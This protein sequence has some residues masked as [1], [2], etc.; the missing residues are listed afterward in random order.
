M[1]RV[2]LAA[3][4]LVILA[5]LGWIFFSSP[6]VFPAASAAYFSQ[7]LGEAAVENVV[8]VGGRSFHVRAGVVEPLSDTGRTDEGSVL[9]VSYAHAVVARNPLLDLEGTDI[10][11]LHEGADSLAR[12]AQQF[13]QRQSSP[14]DAQSVREHLFPVEFLHDLADL[15]RSRRAFL[16]SGSADDFERYIDLLKEAAQQGHRSASAFTE[17]YEKVVDETSLVSLLKGF[18]TKESALASLERIAAGYKRVEEKAGELE[19]CYR[20]EIGACDTNDL[21]LEPLSL[22]PPSP[23]SRTIGRIISLREDAG[24]FPPTTGTTASLAKSTCIPESPH[25]V[26]YIEPKSQRS[27]APAFDLLSDIAFFRIPE[28]L[29]ERAQ[30][31]QAFDA[32][33]VTFLVYTPTAFY[34]CPESADDL[35]RAAATLAA[36]RVAR[37]ENPRD[38]LARAVTPS[39]GDALEYLNRALFDRPSAAVMGVYRMFKDKGASFERLV[40]EIAAFGDAD[41]NLEQ[42]G[43]PVDMSLSFLFSTRSG[44]YQLLLGSNPSALSENPDP[45]AAEEVSTDRLR[46]VWW[47]Q[48]QDSVAQEKLEHD[49]RVYY[50]AHDER[51]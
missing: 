2:A 43:Y 3:G 48:L 7:A 1:N 31:L 46:L 45:F 17:L 4:A 39:E 21:S 35:G 19:R 28:T 44:W 6:A 27:Y 20:G 5:A 47:S 32:Q 9:A 14:S 33:G 18:I 11:A 29:S 40:E 30:V 13:A 15:E 25:S 50:A 23:P 8:V 51:R 24:I 37:T 34:L 36:A 16:N 12:V 41:V 26:F 42:K 10:M 38:A 22:S 49:M